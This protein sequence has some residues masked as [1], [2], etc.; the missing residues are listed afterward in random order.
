MRNYIL[1][2]IFFVSL[3]NCS[4][5]DNFNQTLSL[6]TR[7]FDDLFHHCSAHPEC[8]HRFGLDMQFV[9]R[10]TFEILAESV[11]TNYEDYYDPLSVLCNIEEANDLMEFFWPFIMIS[12]L[13][14]NFLECPLNFALRIRSDGT[15][16]CVCAT[17]SDCSSSSDDDTLI[18]VLLYVLIAAAVVLIIILFFQTIPSYTQLFKNG[19]LA[20]YKPQTLPLSN[21]YRPQQITRRRRVIVRN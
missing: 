10:T 4:L 13:Q 17:G 14:E 9:N 19:P 18:I 15:Q 12:E 20:D 21:G 5:C 2:F 16:Q 3:S 6:G 11:I 1:V 8:A 7:T